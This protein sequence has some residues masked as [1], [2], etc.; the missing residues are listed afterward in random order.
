MAAV[1]SVWVENERKNVL[2]NSKFLR[3]L[4]SFRTAIMLVPP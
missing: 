3:E 1:K 4:I 2:L